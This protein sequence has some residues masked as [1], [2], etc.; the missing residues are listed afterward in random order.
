MNKN[1]LYPTHVQWIHC[2]VVGWLCPVEQYSGRP[3]VGWSMKG[4]DLK[5]VKTSASADWYVCTTMDTAHCVV[6][7]G[8][9]ILWP[10]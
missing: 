5:N 10:G 6:S 2:T 7:M 3:A 4:T 9:S 8:V 1:V